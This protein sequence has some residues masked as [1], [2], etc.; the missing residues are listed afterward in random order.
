M[1]NNFKKK[2]VHVLAT[3]FLLSF[4]FVPS[5]VAQAWSPGQPII[6]NCGD[7]S[8]GC[9]WEDLV[10]QINVIIDVLLYMAMLCAVLSFIYAGF[11][12]LTAGGN[13]SAV[14]DAKQIFKSV[15]MGLIFA[16][17]AWLIVNFITS[18][19]GVKGDYNLL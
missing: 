1:K 12:M 5:Y 10:E 16:Y 19:L 15:V 6:V 17:G 8:A 3:F 14:K 7:G 13:E 11:K 2:G 9:Q 4:F 18:A